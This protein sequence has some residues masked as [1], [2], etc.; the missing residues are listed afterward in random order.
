MRWAYLSKAT[1]RA[2]GG[3]SHQV[4][5]IQKQKDFVIDVGQ[6]IYQHRTIVCAWT[7]EVSSI[8]PICASPGQ[9][10]SVANSFL[11]FCTSHAMPLGKRRGTDA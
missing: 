3:I 11:P 1:L 10:A 8:R 4:I 9:S 7:R 2:Y 6:V 5:I